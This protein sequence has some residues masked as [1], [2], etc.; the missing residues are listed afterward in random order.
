[1][2]TWLDTVKKEN[3]LDS[4]TTLVEAWGHDKGILPNPQA[5][6]QFIKTM[7]EV[8]EL[9]DAIIDNNREEVKDAI[10]DIVVTLI[11]QTQAWDLTLVECVEQAYNF[12]SERTGKMVD[13]IFVKD[14]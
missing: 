13:G 8:G 14:S 11:M 3:T 7:E 12:I 1:M 6:K 2:N 9:Q 5:D 10:G 4:L